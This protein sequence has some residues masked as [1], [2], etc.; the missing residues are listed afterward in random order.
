MTL[1]WLERFQ[2]SIDLVNHNVLSN[3]LTA[4]NLSDDTNK[5]FLSYLSDRKQKVV[6][7]GKFSSEV[8]VLHGVQQ[9]SVLGPLLFNLYVNDLPL[10][11]HEKD[12]V[13]CDM[14]ADDGTLHTTN[15]TVESIS[16]RLQD[17][18]NNNNNN[19]HLYGA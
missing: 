4:Y 18:Y 6:V 10:I 14:F 3:K 5:F 9:G 16:N 8:R 11:L 1:K 2:K 17:N 12:N 15:K 7:N 13:N 19:V